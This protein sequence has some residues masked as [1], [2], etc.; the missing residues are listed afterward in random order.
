[1]NISVQ[2]VIWT[3]KSLYLTQLSSLFPEKRNMDGVIENSV[4]LLVQ[5]LSQGAMKVH[6]SLHKLAVF[7]TIS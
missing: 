1:M 5:N 6:I 7:T 2:F 3:T 4:K